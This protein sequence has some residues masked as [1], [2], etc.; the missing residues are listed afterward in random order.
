M[1]ARKQLP[2]W[3]PI[4]NRR[5]AEGDY[6]PAYTE[7]EISE[8]VD[9]C[10]DSGRLNPAACGWARRPIIRA[11][12]SGHWPR[13]KKW[14]FWNWIC[15][16][17]VFSVTLADIDF[18]A[19]CAVSF[20]DF[21]GG[22]TVSGTVFTR[23]HSFE[24]PEQVELP[25]TFHGGSMEYAN[26]NDGGDIQVR[27]SGLAKNGTKLSADFRVHKPP[28]HESLT[29]VVPW[30][31]ARFQLNC[32]ENT[33][34]CEGSV[35]VGDRGYVMDPTDCHAVLDFGRGMW[36]YRSFWNWAVCTG[37]QDGRRIGVNMGAKWTTGT[38]ANE[39]AVC[40][41]G[42][43]YKIMEDL[44]WDHDPSA[45][46]QPWRVRSAHSDAI[47]LI[48]HPIA[49]HS[50][51]LNLGLLASGGVCV[52]GLWKGTVRI[53]GVVIPINDLIGWAEEFAHRW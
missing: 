18:A 48:L 6:R 23:P 19:F 29:V 8:P 24:M 15:P 32:K 31:A 1:A 3:M 21:E 12:L 26:V 49:A 9:L 43:L 20:T 46:M 53:D 13:K 34:P 2:N 10:D 45:A 30:T 37:V 47:N 5:M 39:N 35:T 14:N 17:F 40:V 42:R 7:P 38:G 28:G 27:F 51:N 36:P 25:V 11:N 50:S 41:D 22:E 52:F 33:R 44:T 16:R 4:V